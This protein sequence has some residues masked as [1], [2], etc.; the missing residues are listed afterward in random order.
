[1]RVLVCG[2]RAFN[3]PTLLFATLDRLHRERNFS[4][5]IHGASRGADR[6]AGD[7]ALHHHIPIISFPAR[8]SDLGNRAGPVRNLLMLKEGRPELVVAFR[9]GHGTFHMTEIAER[10]DVEVMRI[11]WD[12]KTLQRAD[13]ARQ[14]GQAARS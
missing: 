14:A 9:G 1:M 6:L 13:E 2:G 3:N 4:V 12:L 10:A 11:G 7:W 5:V 8:W